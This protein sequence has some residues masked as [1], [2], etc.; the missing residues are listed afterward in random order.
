MPRDVSPCGEHNFERVEMRPGS[1]A[2]KSYGPVAEQCARCGLRRPIGGHANEAYDTIVRVAE[3]LSG[4]GEPSEGEAPVVAAAP[5]PGEGED[6]AHDAPPAPSFPPDAALI[7]GEEPALI[8]RGGALRLTKGRL[9]ELA[10]GAG[11]AVDDGATKEQIIDA[12]TEA[13]KVAPAVGP[14]ELG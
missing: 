4:E 1:H 10:V 5:Q 6:G 14:E 9:L 2:Y 7:G 3:R 13:G 11:L 12:L 8:P